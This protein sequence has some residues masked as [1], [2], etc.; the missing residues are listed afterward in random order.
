MERKEFWT[1]VAFNG[2]LAAVLGTMASTGITAPAG[3]A[4]IW[5]V[6]FAGAAAFVLG[7]NRLSAKAEQTPAQAPQLKVMNGAAA[8]V[9]AQKAA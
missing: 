6:I 7:V 3:A 4:A 2:F 5:S 8:P 9:N 1:S